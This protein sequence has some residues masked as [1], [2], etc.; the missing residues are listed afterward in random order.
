M[1]IY[2]L[3]QMGFAHD[4]LPSELRKGTE[5]CLVHSLSNMNEQ[6]L[7]SVIYAFGQMRCTWTAVRTALQAAI[8]QAVVEKILTMQSQGVHMIL[9][10]L[11]SIVDQSDAKVEKQ[12]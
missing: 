7:S 10:G 11:A 5:R 3:G 9:H 6:E 8:Q 1:T 4:D 2:G 12:H